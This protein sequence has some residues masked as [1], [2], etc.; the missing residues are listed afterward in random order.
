VY[1]VG[2]EFWTEWVTP[3]SNYFSGS[4]ERTGFS[5]Q[6]A[7]AQSDTAGDMFELDSTI[8]QDGPAGG[9]IITPIDLSIVTTREDYGN[10]LKKTCS[11]FELVGDLQTTSSPVNISFS[12]NDYQ[13]FSTPRMIEMDTAG[14]DEGRGWLSRLGAFRRR[15]WKIEHTANTDFRAEAFEVDV[16]QQEY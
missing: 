4:A 2:E 5:V 6:N 13:T 15:A 7:L 11:R 12:D 10:N 1:D 14:S 3:A 9:S 8:Y 16:Q